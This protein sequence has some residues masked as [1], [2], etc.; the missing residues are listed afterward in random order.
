[1]WATNPTEQLA[2]QAL[3][4]DGALHADSLLVSIL[5]RGGN[6]L[7]PFLRVRAEIAA[8]PVETETEVVVTVHLENR[9]PT[10]EPSY[11]TGPHPRSGVG[12]G[13]YLGIL[14]LNLPAEAEGARFDGVDSLA[15]Q[16]QDGP[17][18]VIGFQFELPRDGRRTVVARFRL[19]ARAGSLRVEPSARVPAVRWTSGSAGWTDT[20]ERTVSWAA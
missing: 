18:R 7:D 14:A 8:A 12:E 20:S 6:K 1:M 4:V 15:V 2:W 10:G 17:S 16:G 9:V 13:V 5:N 3:G 11:V 19:P